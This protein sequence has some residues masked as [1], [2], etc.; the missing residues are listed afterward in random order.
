VSN[1]LVDRDFKC[2]RNSLAD[3][4]IT[5][6][7]TSRNEHVLEVEIYI[8]TIK[9]RLRAI[10]SSLPFKKYLLRMMAEMM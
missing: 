3:M 2:I 4:G 10:A 6:N 7:V 5:L 8:R 9:E 1:I